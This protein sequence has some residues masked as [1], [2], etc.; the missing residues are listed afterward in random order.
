[1]ILSKDINSYKIVIIGDGSVGKTAIIDQFIKEVFISDIESTVGASFRTKIV[2]TSYGSIEL[3]I[4]DE[5]G[6]E[7][8]RSLIPLYLRNSSAVIIVVDISE[9]YSNINSLEIWHEIVKINSSNS[10]IYIV[11]NKID[12]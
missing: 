7:R 2:D 5:A 1:M 11:A 12:L 8:Y 6:R 10:R 9:Y 4:W 3:S